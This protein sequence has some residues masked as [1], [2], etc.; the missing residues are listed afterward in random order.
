MGI[1]N[2]LESVPRWSVLAEARTGSEA[3]ATERPDITV[4]LFSLLLSEEV[5]A[6]FRTGSISA[7]RWRRATQ[8]AT[9]LTQCDA[10]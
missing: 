8:P 10:C 1:R 2:L 7:G 6:R 5:I 3:I 4:I 9:C